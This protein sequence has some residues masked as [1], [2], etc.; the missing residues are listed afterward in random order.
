MEKISNDFVKAL[1]TEVR[2]EE[3]DFKDLANDF[4]FVKELNKELSIKYQ[5]FMD[6]FPKAVEIDFVIEK[7]KKELN[8]EQ[9]HENRKYL[10]ERLF[11][12]T[13]FRSALVL[14]EK[15]DNS[16]KPTRYDEVFGNAT[17]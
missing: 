11:H 12:L 1:E 4:E 6:S 7:L 15:N 3:E 2:R 17:A 8:Q 14:I 9:T 5:N 16:I 13:K 10:N